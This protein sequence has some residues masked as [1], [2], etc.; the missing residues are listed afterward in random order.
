MQAFLKKCK[1]LV[2]EGPEDDLACDD[3]D[4]DDEEMRAAEA[5]GNDPDLQ[6]EIKEVASGFQTTMQ[7]LR[8]I[9]KVPPCH[10]GTVQVIV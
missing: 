4:F 3:D 2:T 7:K 9:A 10:G 8:D 6:Q 5:Q 1:V